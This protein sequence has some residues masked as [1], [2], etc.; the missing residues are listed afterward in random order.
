MRLTLTEAA[1]VLGVDKSTVSRIRSGTYDRPGSDLPQRYAALMAL[2]D[3]KAAAHPLRLRDVSDKEL[4]MELC[5]RCPR[6][7]CTGCRVLEI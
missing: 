4:G 2:I 6:E 1:A 5:R 3:A 7:D